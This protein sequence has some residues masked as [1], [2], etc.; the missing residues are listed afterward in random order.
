LYTSIGQT[1]FGADKNKLNQVKCCP[2]SQSMRMQCD[3]PADRHAAS[4]V[5]IEISCHFALLLANQ[6]TNKEQ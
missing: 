1:T 4:W 6:Q 3:S 2:V 5:K